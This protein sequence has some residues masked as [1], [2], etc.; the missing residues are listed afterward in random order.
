MPL[1]DQSSYSTAALMALARA[2]VAA[3]MAALQDLDNFWQWLS[4][5]A[6]ADLLALD[7]PPAQGDLDAMRSAVHDMDA[8]WV[9]FNPPGDLP[10]G[11]TLPYPFGSSARR[12]IGPGDTS[13]R[14]PGR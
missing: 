6:D 8:F 11:M 7:P 12:F 10:D 13:T 1:I 4:G 2:K 14:V 3:V 5:V 9:L